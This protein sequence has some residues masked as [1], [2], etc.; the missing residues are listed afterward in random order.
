MYLYLD[1]CG[2][3]L[4]NT[5]LM[6]ERKP[7]KFRPDNIDLQLALDGDMDTKWESAGGEFKTPRSMITVKEALIV[8]S[9]EMTEEDISSQSR[10]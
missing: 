1:I 3:D 2:P 7:K 6:E 5:F 8:L 9:E 10:N 4:Y